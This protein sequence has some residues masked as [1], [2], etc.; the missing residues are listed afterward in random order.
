M[1][2]TPVSRCLD[3]KLILFGYEVFDLL[4]IF[5]VLS[6]LNLL[7][8]ESGQKLIFV[9]TPTVALALILRLGKRGKPDKYLVHWI[10][11]QMSRGIY[12]AFKEKD[13]AII[14]EIRTPK[15]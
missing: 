15:V 5:L 3:K 6:V 10:K 1:R 2:V 12:S 13:E 9:W 8:G 11:F 4:A 7:F 14:R